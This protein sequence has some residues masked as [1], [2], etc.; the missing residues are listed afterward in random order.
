MQNPVL[1]IS[2]DFELH[3]GR[4]DKYPIREWQEY[5]RNTKQVIPEI[6]ALF[7]KHEI[8]ATWATV[9]MLLAENWEEWHAYSPRVKPEFL[10]KDKSA[11]QWGDYQPELEGLFA[12]ELVKLISQ[13]KG[14]EL[15][16][17]TFSHFY[18]GEKGSNLNAFQAD[19]EACKRIFW[20]KMSINPTSLVFPRNQYDDSVLKRASEAGFKTFRTNPKDWF[21]ENT[22]RETLMKKIF[23]TGDTLLPLGHRTSF[24]EIDQ[25][26]DWTEIP[27]SRLLRPFREGSIFN[28]R[29]I[30]RIKAELV[31]SCNRKEI[32]HLWW[33]P[34]NFGFLPQENLS[35]LEDLLDFIAELKSRFDLQSLNMDE[36]AGL[37]QKILKESI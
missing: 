10:Q 18:T 8:H 28:S 4:F 31:E 17:H 30:E 16:S 27:A 22:A 32:Y 6:L 14:Q 19:L 35:I 7:E 34:H 36:L 1:V 20:D 26:K 21:W 15:G 9:G 37:E 12:P 11:Y 2:L 23:R 29:R 33:H 5:Y 13:T 25:K 3:W 24:P